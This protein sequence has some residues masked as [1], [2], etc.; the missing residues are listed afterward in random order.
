MNI[1]K[2]FTDPKFLLGTVVA[3]AVAM[4]IVNRV[5]KAV[6]QVDAIVNG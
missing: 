1:G 2:L 5:A 3:T 4:A 6:P